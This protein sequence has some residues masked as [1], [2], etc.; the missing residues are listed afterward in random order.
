MACRCRYFSKAYL[1]VV[2]AVELIE[3][4]LAEGIFTEIEANRAQVTGMPVAIRPAILLP[5]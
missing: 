2:F 4:S 3:D 5:Q 1:A